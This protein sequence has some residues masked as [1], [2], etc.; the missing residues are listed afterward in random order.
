MGTVHKF[1]RPPK[2]QQQF[3]GYQPQAQQGLGAGGKRGRWKLRDWQG[4]VVA[5][6]L[7]V[8]IA[9]IIWAIGAFF[10]GT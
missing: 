3:R 2:N 7:L 6:C 10:G 9:T 4:S 5:W 8:L 1:K